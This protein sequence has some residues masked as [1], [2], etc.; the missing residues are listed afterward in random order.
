MLAPGRHL[1]SHCKRAVRALARR[2]G[3]A[4]LDE[5]GQVGVVGARMAQLLCF[6]LSPKR[7][8]ELLARGHSFLLGGECEDSC[9][10]LDSL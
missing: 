4:R 6:L 5:S 3:A 7:F 8:Y 2:E 9:A 10:V 1:S